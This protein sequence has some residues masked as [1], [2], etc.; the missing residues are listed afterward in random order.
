MERLAFTT[1]N[2]LQRFRPPCAS[3]ARFSRSFIGTL[4]LQAR[5]GIGRVSSP[6][7]ADGERVLDAAVVDYEHAVAA[8]WRG[9]EGKVLILRP[10]RYVMG[11]FPESDPE[12]AALAIEALLRTTGTADEPGLV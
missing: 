3:T 7:C 11:A 12:S 4:Y 10:D 9:Y 8:A 1:V 2:W 6:L 5:R